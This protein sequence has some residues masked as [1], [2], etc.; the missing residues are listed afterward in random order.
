MRRNTALKKGFSRH[1]AF[2]LHIPPHWKEPCCIFSCNHRTK[3]IPAVALWSHGDP[4]L[5]P[6]RTCVPAQYILGAKPLWSHLGS[7]PHEHLETAKRVVLGES[8]GRHF[9]HSELKWH[10]RHP[11]SKLSCFKSSSMIQQRAPL[12]HYTSVS[13]IRY[14]QKQPSLVNHSFQFT[15]VWLLKIKKKYII[16]IYAVV[17]LSNF[18]HRS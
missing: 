2:L 3:S 9:I 6:R 7:I 16:H 18:H 12:H 17:H 4:S 11:P 10:K 1:N 5:T 8:W 14:R 13:A 15:A